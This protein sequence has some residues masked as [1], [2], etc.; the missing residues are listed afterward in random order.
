MAFKLIV[1]GLHEGDNIPKQHT[2][3]GK[4]VSPALKWDGAPSTTRSFALI[5][6]DPDAPAGTWNHWLLWNIPPATTKIDA[7]YQAGQLGVDGSN[8]FGRAGYNGP[9]PPKG[10]GPHRYFFRLYAVD[11]EALPVKPQAKRAEL[12][13]ALNGHVIAEAIYMGHYERR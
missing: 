7:G 3:E 6:D 2:C 12:D 11:V 1:E 4:D 5:M 10:H 9:C 8:D 13:L